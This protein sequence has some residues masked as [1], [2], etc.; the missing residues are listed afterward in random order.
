MENIL[1]KKTT[2]DHPSIVREEDC[3]VRYAYYLYHI[4][5]ILPYGLILRAI[6]NRN[7]DLQPPS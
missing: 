5:E 7:N 4:G 3:T 2:I 6:A 1:Q